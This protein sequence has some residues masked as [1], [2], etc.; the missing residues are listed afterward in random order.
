MRIS[1]PIRAR[2]LLSVAVGVAAMAVGIVP[3]SA[4]NVSGELLIKGVGYNFTHAYANFQS[5]R[6][7]SA[8]TYT[9]RIVNNGP[10]TSQYR[11]ELRQP[12]ATFGE[13]TI[14]DGATA[15]PYGVPYF[16]P[17]LAP[18]AT[19]NITV[20]ITSLQNAVQAIDDA[21]VRLY[22]G[23]SL[24]ELDE[25]LV[26]FNIAAPS[27]GTTPYDVFVRNGAQL[28]VGGSV[29]DQAMS[30]PPVRQGGAGTYSI[31]LQNDGTSATRI[32]LTSDGPYCAGVAVSFRSG[33]A[34]VTTAVRSGTFQSNLLAPG[35]YQDLTATMKNVAAAPSCADAAVG[36]DTSDPAGAPKVLV[37]LWLPFVATS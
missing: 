25:H 28:A 14:Y 19:K 16:S 9:V 11:V 30:A 34:D 21:N 23:S 18:D 6:A 13:A 10:V 35:A 33:F 12:S 5:G 8:V 32:G 4:A 29:S 20:R 3:A 36:L 17:P 24:L 27:R 37:Y 26:A 15:V 31:R 22:D 2:A 7:G 1:F